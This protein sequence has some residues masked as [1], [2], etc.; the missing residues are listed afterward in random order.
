MA[1]KLVKQ[2]KVKATGGK[3]TPAPPLGPVLGQAGI[4]I[5]GM[6]VARSEVGGKAL[7]ALTVDSDVSD[8]ILATIKK[9]T[10]AESVRAVVLVD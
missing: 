7:M 4:N 6:Q 8:E 5:A 3:A 1:K 9:E 2:I 10:N